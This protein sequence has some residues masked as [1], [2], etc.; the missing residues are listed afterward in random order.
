MRRNPIE[1]NLSAH[2]LSRTPHKPM[3][4]I[5]PFLPALVRY[6]EPLMC[7]VQQDVALDQGDRERDPMLLVM[8]LDQKTI[9]PVVLMISF[10]NA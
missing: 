4:S 10:S 1:T 6:Q 5:A 3:P 9:I 7:R 8:C 2:S